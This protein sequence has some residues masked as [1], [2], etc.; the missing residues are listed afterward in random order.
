MFTNIRAKLAQADS[1]AAIVCFCALF[2]FIGVTSIF[3]SDMYVPS[4]PH[5]TKYFLT[6]STHVKLTISIFFLSFA[7]SPLIYGPLSDRFG[8]RKIILFGAAL[9]FIGSVI[10]AFSPFIDVLIIGR[11]IQGAGAGALMCV[12]RSI[13][14]DVLSGSRLAQVISYLS[15]IYGI[16]PAVAP[17]AGGY[18][19][20]YFGWR[21]IFIFMIF[22]AALAI[23]IIWIVLPE[24]NKRLNIHATKPKHM[25]KNYATLLSSRIFISNAISTCAAFSGIL[26]YYTMTP[27]L[28]QNTLHITTI[29]FGWLTVIVAV[30]LFLGKGINILLV[31]RLRLPAVLLLGNTIM[32]LAAVLMLLFAVSGIMTISA[33]LI[34]MMIFVAGTGLVM[35]NA[36]A[37]AIKPFK[38]M[39]GAASSLYSCLQMLAT[40]IVSYI[41]ARLHEHN[42]IPL[43]LLLTVLALLPLVSYWVLHKRTH[44]C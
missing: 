9:F 16:M 15:L 34:P 27:F 38:E 41:A 28:F 25:L 8:R 20:N 24:T 36:F 17:V 37:G 12:N 43:A 40:F 18:L 13:A 26:A 4:L 39:A 6:T 10:C 2:I 42:Q 11:F 3:A 29:Q 5:I 19:Q 23:I 35:A 7:L 31:A 44:R 22:Y 33:V 14:S 30:S 1:T 21:S 32:F